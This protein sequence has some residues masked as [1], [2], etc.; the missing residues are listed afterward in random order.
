M[1]GK[2]KIE[3][4]S[5]LNEF[6]YQAALAEVSIYV[7]NEPELD[8]K[9]ADRFRKLLELIEAYESDHYQVN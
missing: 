2:V 1:H 7:D 5:I 6:D 8:S 9:N 4:K 3:P